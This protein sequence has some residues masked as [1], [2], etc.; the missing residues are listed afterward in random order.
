MTPPPPATG[1]RRDWRDLPPR[2]RLADAGYL[3]SPVA[4]AATQPGGFTSVVA[5][6][7]KTLDGRRAFLKVVG[8]EP[9]PHSPGMH[10]REILVAGALPPSAPVPR[11]NWSYA[12]SKVEDGWVACLF[13][14]IAGC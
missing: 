9:N 2:L 12:E 6:R 7:L 3:G 4:V 8:P 14:D 11:I 5:A 13:E 10:R 1:S